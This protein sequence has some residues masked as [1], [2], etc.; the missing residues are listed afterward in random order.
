MVPRGGN[1]DKWSRRADKTGREGGREGGREEGREE[2][3][4]NRGGK[5][6]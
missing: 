2:K 6:V 3:E 4:I 1:L 5:K